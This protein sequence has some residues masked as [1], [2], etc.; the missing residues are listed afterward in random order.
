MWAK[1]ASSTTSCNDVDVNADLSLALEAK[2]I[3]WALLC[4]T[5]LPCIAIFAILIVFYYHSLLGMHDRLARC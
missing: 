3:S 1:F 2:S 4:S 5:L